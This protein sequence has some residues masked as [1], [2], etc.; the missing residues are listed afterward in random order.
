MQNRKVFAITLLAAFF[1]GWSHSA[2]AQSSDYKVQITPYAFMTGVNGTIGEQGRTANVD[3]SFGDIIDHLNMVAMVYFDAR[4]GRWRVLVDNLYTD[5]ASAKATPG[6]LFS[7]VR[8]ATRMWIVDPEAGYAIFQGEG[9][10]LDV[11]A[12]ARL[13][14]LD[15]TLTLS[16]PNF[17]LDRGTGTRT[18]ADPIVGGR[19]YADIGQKM[20]VTAKAD[21]GGFNAGASTDWQA[22]GAAGFKFNDT[23]VVSLGYRYLSIDYKNGNSIYDVHLNGVILGLGFRF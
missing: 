18:V 8:V 11:T 19:Y 17:A 20:F 15:N 2:Q 3:A 7:S 4:L 1:C 21:I 5:V 16:R 13:W 22:F 10:E 9:K 14:N 12:G 23:I 6:P